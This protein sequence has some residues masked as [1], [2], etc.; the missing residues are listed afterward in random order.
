MKTPQTE[1]SYVLEQI[2]QQNKPKQK[3]GKEEMHGKFLTSKHN[4]EVKGKMFDP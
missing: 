4:I 2:R 1:K 3:A